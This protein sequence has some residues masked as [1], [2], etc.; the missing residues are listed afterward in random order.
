[1]T[2]ENI[3]TDKEKAYLKAVI[4]PVKDK[5]IFI[6]KVEYSI[7]QKQFVYIDLVDGGMDTYTFEKNTQ[8]IN[9]ELDKEYTLKELGLE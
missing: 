1:M 2:K 4:E 7:S 6:Q 8:F 9:M 3:L 5:V